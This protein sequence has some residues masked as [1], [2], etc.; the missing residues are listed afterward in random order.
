MIFGVKC[1][2]FLLQKHSHYWNYSWQQLMN[3]T[4][5]VHCNFR[6]WLNYFYTSLSN[7]LC[8]TTRTVCGTKANKQLCLFAIDLAALNLLRY[9]GREVLTYKKKKNHSPESLRSWLLSRSVN[10]YLFVSMTIR[11][12]SLQIKPESI[13]WFCAQERHWE[14]P[15]QFP[16]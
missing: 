7:P 6:W 15:K 14:M 10:V 2:I 13:N 8:A 3:I 11:H 4:G 5:S 16:H 9:Y 12:P 1:I